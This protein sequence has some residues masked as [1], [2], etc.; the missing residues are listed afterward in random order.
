VNT[1]KLRPLYVSSLQLNLNYSGFLC[2]EFFNFLYFYPNKDDSLL[3]SMENGDSNVINIKVKT[4]D[5]ALHDFTVTK[6]TS[7]SELK[8]KI[9]AVFPPFSPDE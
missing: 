7:I 6:E 5:N 4:L 1:I 9:A 3:D 2:I 8:T